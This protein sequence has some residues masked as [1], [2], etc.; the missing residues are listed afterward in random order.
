MEGRARQPR[1]FITTEAMAAT[2][3][4]GIRRSVATQQPCEASLHAHLARGVALRGVGVIGR[5]ETDHLAF[6]PEIFERRLIVVDQRYDDL[7]VA[8]RLGAPD[9]RIVAVEDA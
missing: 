6:A 9:E 7:A 4:Q 8:G 1:A 5:I 3:V 2:S